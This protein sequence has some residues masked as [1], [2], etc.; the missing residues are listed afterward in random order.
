MPNQF[1]SSPLQ[2]RGDLGQTTSRHELIA[3]FS[4]M[5]G[6][7][8][9]PE[10]VSDWIHDVVGIVSDEHRVATDDEEGGSRRG[11]K[12]DTQ[13]ADRKTCHAYVRVGL[14]MTR[15]MGSPGA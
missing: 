14:D 7:L 2:C 4:V 1:R 15:F 10:G 8:A 3:C 13:A 5:P 12:L 11:L 9:D 6:L